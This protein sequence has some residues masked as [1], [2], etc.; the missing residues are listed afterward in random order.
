MT[1]SFAV[2][3]D[4][5]CPFARNFHEHVLTGLA[6][7]ADWDVRFVAF[8]LDQV[9]VEEGELDAWDN[10]VVCRSLLAGQVGVAIRDQWPESFLDAH[11]ALFACR[12][13][14]GG[15]LRDKAVL[16]AAIADVGLDPDA[17]FAEVDGGSP[18]ATF[19]KEHEGS[20]AEHRVFGVPTI[21]AG[22]DAVFVRVMHRPRRDG[23]VAIRTVE[24]V[25]DLLVGWPELN[26]FK[27]T[28]IPR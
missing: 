17:V 15:D 5:R 24:R 16:R 23:E 27:H 4:Y 9:H 19:R 14:H 20:V 25:L 7:G 11:A 13:D 1:R 12:H 6:A 18:L 22:D 8:S 28:I 21:I 3:W 2:T 26:E 10:P